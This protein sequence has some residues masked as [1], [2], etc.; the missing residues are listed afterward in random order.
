M[1]AAGQRGPE[2]TCLPYLIYFF[3]SGPFT[4]RENS[5]WGEIYKSRAF[6]PRPLSSKVS[7]QAAFYSKRQ[8]L[9]R[10]FRKKKKE[11]P[12][13]PLRTPGLTEPQPE[14]PLFV[15]KPPSLAQINQS[16][17]AR[18]ACAS[19]HAAPGRGAAGRTAR[20]DPERGGTEVPRAHRLR[21]SDSRDIPG[22][23]RD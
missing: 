15:R 18:S 11:R 7:Y 14:A 19:H 9:N 6:D 8:F 13:S 4:A 12:P 23:I 1:R 17:T 21:F 16:K 20:P 3:L 10:G 5:R 2:R 22:L